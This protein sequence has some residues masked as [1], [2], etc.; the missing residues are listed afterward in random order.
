MFHSQ[1]LPNIEMKT[2]NNFN[3]TFLSAFKH[4]NWNHQIYSYLKRNRNENKILII[5]ILHSH[6]SNMILKFCIKLKLRPFQ[7]CSNL[8]P[9]L[10]DLQTFTTII[11]SICYSID[12][13]FFFLSFTQYSLLKRNENHFDNAQTHA[14]ADMLD[15]WSPHLCT[16]HLLQQMF[17]LNFCRSLNSIRGPS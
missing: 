6:L 3:L 14:L 2:N 4:K 10:L 16:V 9:R 5:Y 7:Y 8:F 15:L 1:S 17:H 12:L 13:L 11:P